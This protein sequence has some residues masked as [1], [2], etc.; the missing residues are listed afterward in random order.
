MRCLI[1]ALSVAVLHGQSTPAVIQNTGKPMAIQVRCT[2]ETIH[3]LGL[4]CSIEQPCPLYLDL[5]D[6]HAV[7]DR[8]VVAGNLHTSSTTLE[9]IL[10]ASDDVGK[11]WFEAHPRIAM[12]ILDHIQ[13]YDF[14]IG[15]I[16]GHLLQAIPRDAFF[17]ITSDGGKTWRKRPI[18]GE[19]RPGAIEHFWFDS[20]TRGQLLIER[21]FSEDGIK[22]EL[23]ESMT[24]GDSWNVRQVDSK[25]I[26]L[27]RPATPI[28]WR[29]RSDAKTQS[30]RIERE[31]GSKWAMV[32]SFSINPGECKPPPPPE[33]EP[34]KET[35][36]PEP[37]S[38]APPKPSPLS[39][40]Q[41]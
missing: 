28:A 5:S 35:V 8:L 29:I 26:P 21:P 18:F 9:S 34:S 27:S 12:A 16:N 15:W 4:A 25:P 24:G 10:L 17:L 20:R 19:S 33:P 41:R 13:F 37:E 30:H 7:G 40:L 1:V 6:I 2:A 3:E 31:M 11:T 38:P 39:D 23:W 36:A 22:H 32:A 14:E